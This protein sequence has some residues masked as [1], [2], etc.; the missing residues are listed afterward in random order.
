[1][2]IL[3]VSGSA[4]KDSS[5]VRL[6]DAL[7]AL[8]PTYTFH[9]FEHLA[10]LPLFTADVQHLKSPPT[11]KAWK[12]ALQKNDAVIICTPEYIHNLPALLKNALEWITESGELAEKK[13]LAI[14]FTPNPPR[15]E[16]AMQSLTWSLQALNA[17]VVAQLPMYAN[18]ISFDGKG[19]I[20][21]SDSS[22][23]LEEAIQL[24]NNS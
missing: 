23:M 20:Q 4:R 5:N 14:T 19:G 10:K 21:E 13:V 18:E 2:N 12:E 22:T 9:R 15:G 7:P 24:L 1:M 3:T 6:L 16:K 17:R 11:V 8:I